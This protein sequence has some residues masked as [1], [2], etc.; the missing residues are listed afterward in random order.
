M[1]NWMA[2]LLLMCLSPLALAAEP[3]W[4]DVRTAEEYRQEHLPGAVNIPHT[5]IARGVTELYPDKQTSLNLYCRSGNRS[6]MAREAL[7]ALGYRNVVDHGALE[8]LKAAGME[9]RSAAEQGE[10]AP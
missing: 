1:K 5:R 7:Q 4:I 6:Q 8:T 9:T 10:P 2:A 3:V